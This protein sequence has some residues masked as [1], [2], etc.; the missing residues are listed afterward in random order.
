MKL[1]A[2]QIVNIHAYPSESKFLKCECSVTPEEI[3]TE[4]PEKFSGQTLYKIFYD[5]LK[6]IMFIFK[7][8]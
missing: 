2:K 8:I 5:V 4:Q 1:H 6:Y 3:E 7:K